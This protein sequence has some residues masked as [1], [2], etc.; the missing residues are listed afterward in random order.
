MN[1]IQSNKEAW[2]ES[3]DHR[4]PNWGDDIYK[5][6]KSE[7]LP[8]FS[9]DVREELKKIDFSN[10][11]V[12]Q[13]CCNN[14]RELLS[15]MQL[16]PANGVGFDIAENI[17]GQAID[18][19]NKVNQTN[20]RFVACNILEIDPKYYNSFDFIMF[21]IGA[22]TWFEDLGQ[23]LKKVALCLKP[24]GIFFINDYHPFIG[25]LPMP[26]EEE[27]DSEQKNRIMYSYFR[28]E[29]WIENSGMGYI[30]PEFESKTFTSFSHTMSDLINA[31]IQNGMQIKS[32]QEYNYDVGMTDV[33]NGLG[34]P[35]SFILIAKKE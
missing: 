14:G 16:G 3:F 29:P 28:K 1:Y 5:T 26:G 32:L 8:F 19:A 22:I 13:F 2:E 34:Y 10:K 7:S 21:T 35:L 15:L 12:A 33:Y 9:D 17:I 27:F 11:S 4:Y 31:S 23:L 18:T 30:S 24:G 6:L 25:M 20:C